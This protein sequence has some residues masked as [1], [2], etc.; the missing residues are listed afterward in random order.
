MN[1]CHTPWY[2]RSRPFTLIELLVV[3]SIIA[4]LAAMLL[5]ALTRARES[6]RQALCTSNLK[7]TVIMG[8]LYESDAEV[9]LPS[10]YTRPDGDMYWN[11]SLFEAGYLNDDLTYGNGNADERHANAARSTSVLTCPSG[12]FFW[13]W[14]ATLTSNLPGF[15]RLDGYRY[16]PQTH[17][18]R[19]WAPGKVRIAWSGYMINHYFSTTPNN[20]QFYPRR[21][22]EEDPAR[23]LF[24]AEAWR[25]IIPTY[26]K[27][28]AAPGTGQ[29]NSQREFRFPHRD[30]GLFAT[31]DGHI[32]SV[33][34][35]QF[36]PFDGISGNIS[37]ADP[38]FRSFPYQF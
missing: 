32:E 18:K 2:L 15:D 8:H 22:F 16:W 24:F 5:P 3:V 20:V 9:L 33:Q 30:R 38:A 19:T 28:E 35:L 17:V 12:E 14:D 6:A 31:Y 29:G 21:R 13:P 4:I 37:A 36:L 34:R 11:V 27:F 10:I 1:A 7:Q 25:T 23:K 26:M